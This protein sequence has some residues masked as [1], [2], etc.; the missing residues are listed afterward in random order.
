MNPVQ[1]KA[2]PKAKREP[3]FYIYV[4][5]AITMLTAIGIFTW[6]VFQ[7][8]RE[9]GH[10]T[11]TQS[12]QTG[13]NY[14]ATGY[15]ELGRFFPPAYSG[16]QPATPDFAAAMKLYTQRDYAAATAA[17][18][19]VVG[20]H[21]DFVAARFYLGICEIYA[22][23]LAAGIA[24]LRRVTAAGSTPYL[25]P[26]LFYVGKALL[27]S[28]DPVGARQQFEQVIALHGDF[29]QQAESLLAKLR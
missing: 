28:D 19:S 27:S 8:S 5:T 1:A 11:A 25:E 20:A 24:D 7:S 13:G 23:D 4:G 17:L 18:R 10:V 21:P 6:S 16:G 3:W 29:E 14:S 12:P 22:N 9:G 2:T 26:S 15:R